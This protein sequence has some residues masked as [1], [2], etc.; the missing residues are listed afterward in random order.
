LTHCSD[1]RV[2]LVMY[3][4]RVPRTFAIVAACRLPSSVTGHLTV[5]PKTGSMNSMDAHVALMFLLLVDKFLAD[6]LLT[7]A[8][9]MTAAPTSASSALVYFDIT[10]PFIEI[11]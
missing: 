2:A 5:A 9:S 8:L 7:S 10:M 3:P 4:I 1:G 11:T 6:A